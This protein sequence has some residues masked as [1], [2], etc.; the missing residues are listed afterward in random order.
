MADDM[1]CIMDPI[2]KQNARVNIYDFCAVDLGFCP[3]RG[4]HDPCNERSMH[5]S[6]IMHGWKY[7]DMVGDINGLLLERPPS[8]LCVCVFVLLISCNWRNQFGV[9]CCMSHFAKSYNGILYLCV[10]NGR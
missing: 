2:K 8:R 1:K 10:S 6:C 4:T 7:M 5:A 3:A 9:I